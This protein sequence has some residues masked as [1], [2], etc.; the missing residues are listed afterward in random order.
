[1]GYILASGCSYTDPKY[2]IETPDKLTTHMSRPIIT[3]DAWPA[4]IAK[5]LN[6]KCVNLG[7][8]GASNNRII[9]GLYDYIMK[10]KERPDEVYVMLSSWDRLELLDKTFALGV[11]LQNAQ[12]KMDFLKILLIKPI[13]I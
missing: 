9:N 4:I 11:Y 5:R 13:L 3:W 1:M 8:S 7:K 12:M 2:R 6:K 10:A